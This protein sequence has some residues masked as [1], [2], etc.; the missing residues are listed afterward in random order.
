VWQ[1]ELTPLPVEIW[2]SELDELVGRCAW[3]SADAAD[4]AVRSAYHLSMLSPPP[5]RRL[6]GN[7]MSESEL[8]DL[9]ERGEADD[10][11]AAIAE[12]AG[13]IHLIQ[14]DGTPRYVA[15]FDLDEEEVAF[16]AASPALAIVGAWA[17][18]LTTRQDSWVR[19][20]AAMHPVPLQARS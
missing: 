10:V 12:S 2:L 8:E 17:S 16:E 6:F 9:L 19:N 20:W 4:R 1:E 7:G 18:A 13:S 11:A 3:L 14:R 5:V 15:T